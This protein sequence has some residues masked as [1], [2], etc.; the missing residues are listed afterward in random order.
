MLFFFCLFSLAGSL[1]HR[2]SL[3]V[4]HLHSHDPHNSTWSRQVDISPKRLHDSQQTDAFTFSVGPFY[5]GLI[6]FRI[7]CQIMLSP[8]QLRGTTD[9]T[10]CQLELLGS[11]ALSFPVSVWAAPRVTF[12]V[13]QLRCTVS[14][15]FRG[16]WGSVWFNNLVHL[17]WKG[18]IPSI[19]N[20]FS[21]VLCFREQL[22]LCFHLNY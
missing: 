13:T 3:C 10:S 16:E 15:L 6:F 8:L 21:S 18:S 20:G 19:F 14:V 4:L 12:S 17:S 22:F 1:F 9:E 5:F 2:Q 7:N 11:A